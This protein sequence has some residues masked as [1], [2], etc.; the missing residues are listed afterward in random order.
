MPVGR[1]GKPE[2]IATACLFF[3]SEDALSSNG[4]AL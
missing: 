3:A 2:D 4:Q 1:A